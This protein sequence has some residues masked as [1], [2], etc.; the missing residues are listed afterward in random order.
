MAGL[1][2]A[3]REPVVDGVKVGA[4][5]IGIDVVLALV[6]V[7]DRMAGGDFDIDN[8]EAVAEFMIADAM[9]AEEAD[10]DVEAEVLKIES[11][12]ANA[13]LMESWVLGVRM[14]CGE[15]I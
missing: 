3:T 2:D 4:K 15:S 7:T 1:M 10:T 12:V 13:A 9:D 11:G 5:E 6:D 8:T 14:V